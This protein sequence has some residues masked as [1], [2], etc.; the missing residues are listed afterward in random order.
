MCEHS[1]FKWASNCILQLANSPVLTAV[2][3]VKQM[4]VARVNELSR[5]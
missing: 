1:N 3:V 4:F 2:D 5:Y